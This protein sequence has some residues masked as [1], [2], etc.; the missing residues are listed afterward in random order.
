MIG[1]T[2]TAVAGVAATAD[3]GGGGS[4]SRCVY[5]RL[6]LPPGERVYDPDG[7]AYEADGPGGWYVRS[8]QGPDGR[9]DAYG[10]VFVP[11]AVDPLTLAQE[12]LRRLPLPLPSVGTSPPPDRDQ[13]VHV[14]TWLWVEDAWAPVSATASVPGVS[15]TVTAVPDSVAWEMGNGDSVVCDGPGTPYDPSR[16]DAEQSTDCSYTYTASSAGQPGERFTVTATQR[17]RV[18]WTAIG[19]AGGGD[20]GT[21]SRSTQ[22]T[23]RVAEGQA[24]VTEGR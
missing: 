8:C 2:P 12:A 7:T 14:P 22:F 1:G 16:P 18:T 11:D 3:G 5:E 15:V 17:W 4:G 24:L 6:T 10:V 23:L 19:V 21:V 9:Q 13:V 20:L